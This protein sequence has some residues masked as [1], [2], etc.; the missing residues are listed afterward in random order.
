MS[1]VSGYSTGMEVVAAV[2]VM[3]IAVLGLFLCWFSWEALGV[4]FGWTKEGIERY[5]RKDRKYLW[6]SALAVPV[7][8]G[9]G[10]VIGLIVRPQTSTIGST[11]QGDVIGIAVAY[12]FVIIVQFSVRRPEEGPG[13][14]DQA[15]IH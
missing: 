10:S 7:C 15:R 5:P 14:G 4:L 9:I 3:A 6:A 8:G 13:E 1:T 2:A 12:A 11:V